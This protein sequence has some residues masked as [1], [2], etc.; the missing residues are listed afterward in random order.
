[1]LH[2]DIFHHHVVCVSRS[3][4]YTDSTKAHGAVSEKTPSD[5]FTRST[6][7]TCDRARLA[8]GRAN[9]VGGASVGR[10]MPRRS[11]HDGLQDEMPLAQT[12]GNYV[13]AHL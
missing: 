2:G 9:E 12:A 13:V 7:P 4:Q 8:P 3:T 6:Y 11:K 1:M 10:D 5:V